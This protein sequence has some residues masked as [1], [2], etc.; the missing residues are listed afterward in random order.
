MFLKECKRIV[1]KI[2][3]RTVFTS[4]NSWLLLSLFVH[5][6]IFL[7]IMLPTNHST[8]QLTSARSGKIKITLVSRKTKPIDEIRPSKINKFEKQIVE[9]AVSLDKKKVIS[10]FLS[11]RKNFFERQ[12]VAK[13]VAKFSNGAG[14]KGSG[15]QEKNLTTQQQNE[16]TE[17]KVMVPHTRSHQAV[18]IKNSVKKNTKLQNLALAS[19][20]IGIPPLT[21]NAINQHI[22]RNLAKDQNSKN[23]EKKNPNVTVADDSSVASGKIEDKVAASND[24]LKDIPLGDFTK[25]NTDE[26]KYFG[27]YQRI[28]RQLEQYWGSTLK[29]KTSA[30]YKSGRKIAK[31]DDFITNLEIYLDPDGK[32]QQIK[33]MTS[34]G[35][36][37]LDDAAI[38]SFNKAGPFPNPPKELVSSGFA[39]IKWGFVV[40]S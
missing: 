23:L 3:Q 16:K 36:R 28:R 22:D 37:E 33:V 40:R 34:S 18:A 15:Q 26:Y 17:R 11:D 9:S 2:R 10:R 12:T 30:I 5:A 21:D 35:V 29:E 24:Y 8:H 1:Q 27:F 39:K 13:N 14:N 38:E 19:V 20:G 32:I 25:L 6:L 4:F 31:E 7:K